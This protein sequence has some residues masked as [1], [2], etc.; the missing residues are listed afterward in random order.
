MFLR[1]V[2]FALIQLKIKHL[3]AQSTNKKT[4]SVTVVSIINN[5]KLRY[6]YLIQNL[7]EC[8]RYNTQARVWRSLFNLNRTVL[9]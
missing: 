5:D 3:T 2:L 6:L 9:L 1:F 4:F 7:L 8:M